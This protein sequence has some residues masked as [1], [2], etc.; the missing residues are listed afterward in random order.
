MDNY[1]K[2]YKPIKRGLRT[3]LTIIGTIL[4]IIAEIGL[5]V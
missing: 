5:L 4:A 3:V 2:R 1:L